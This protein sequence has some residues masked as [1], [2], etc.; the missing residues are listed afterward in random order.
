M[1]R[2][3]KAGRHWGSRETK[4][5]NVQEDRRYR[6]DLAK[7]KTWVLSGVGVRSLLEARRP[8]GR[9]ATKDRVVVT[10]RYG[11]NMRPWVEK[12][13]RTPK[14]EEGYFKPLQ[15]RAA[16]RRPP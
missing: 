16:F 2:S 8:E 7:L 13:A 11:S 4:E 10:W 15:V 3:D 6:N 9:K 5:G 12:T 14:R 1:C